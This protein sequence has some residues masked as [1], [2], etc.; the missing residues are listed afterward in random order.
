M[1]HGIQ[2]IKVSGSAHHQVQT[3]YPNFYSMYGQVLEALNSARYLGVDIALDLKFTKHINRIT[4]NAPKSLGYLK[5]NIQTKHIGITVGKY[6]RGS[7]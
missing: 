2:S 7:F 1:G 4:A 6:K 3:T 5:R